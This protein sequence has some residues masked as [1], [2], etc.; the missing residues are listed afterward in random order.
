MT[1][2]TLKR[3]FIALPVP[4]TAT[5]FLQDLTHLLKFSLNQQPRSKESPAPRITWEPSANYH[6]TLK[7]LGDTDSAQTDLVE[8]IARE[9]ARRC[10]AFKLTLTTTELFKT[11]RGGA[12]VVR[13]TTKSSSQALWNMWDELETR[14]TKAGFPTADFEFNPHITIAKTSMRRDD[15]PIN[16]ALGSPI[17]HPPVWTTKSIGLFGADTNRNHQAYQQV[18]NWA[19]G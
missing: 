11:D 13:T 12:I 8:K 19:L 15:I 6:I 14:L 5:R 9:A 1:D 16:W 17:S 7:Y 10:P 2:R 3:T 4:R 18:N